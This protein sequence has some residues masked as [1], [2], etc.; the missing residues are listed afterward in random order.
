MAFVALVTLVSALFG[1]QDC[2][3]HAQPL[4]QVDRVDGAAGC[5]W[6]SG[7]LRAALG[8][9]GSGELLLV[10]SGESNA[11]FAVT[12]SL[13]ATRVDR[14]GTLQWPVAMASD[15]EALLIVERGAG[16]VAI[17]HG[18]THFTLGGGVLRT[19]CAVA[20]DGTLVA[21]ADDGLGEVLVFD[22][23]A[24]NNAIIARHQG[25][26]PSGVAFDGFG[27]LWWSDAEKHQLHCVEDHGRGASKAFGERGSFPGQ[28]TEP[29]A[30]AARDGCL[31][32]A[33]HLNHRIAIVHAANGAFMGYW[34]MHAVVPRQG[35]GRIHYPD[36]IALNADGRIAAITEGFEDRVQLF[37]TGGAASVDDGLGSGK[38]A[39]SS[40]FGSE[41]ACAGGL[42]AMHEPETGAV[43]LFDAINVPPYNV[44]TVGASGAS[45]GRYPSISA[46]G[47]FP[48]GKR[49]V[50][51]DASRNVFDVWACEIDRTQ[52]LIWN[53]FGARLVKSLD[54]T[55]LRNADG[56]KPERTPRIVDIEF[57]QETIYAL[58]SA[59]RSIVQL[60]WSFA[61]LPEVKL[62]EEIR[63]PVEFCLIYGLIVVADPASQCLWSREGEKPDEWRE[64][65]T[66]LLPDGPMP[67]IRPM[68]VA[69]TAAH[70]LVVSDAGRDSVYLCTPSSEKTVSA[71]VARALS[72]RGEL[73]EEFWM[74][75]GVA[76]LGD[77]FT[78]VDR[79]NHRFQLFDANGQWTLTTS[80]SR[81]YTRK[82]TPATDSTGNES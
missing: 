63:E 37:A 33:D 57:Q 59:N 2:P 47:V 20:V 30:L 68:G 45:P 31:F 53:A 51:A 34:G 74:P 82:R 64:I 7:D 58:D 48:D 13:T 62:P 4:R 40:H 78:A 5:A 16:R 21:V 80:L 25:T 42:L 73:D 35:D 29:R 50:I 32:V 10:S 6:I 71:Q 41:V 55:K 11:V 18:D 65:R 79:G 75:L 60:S 15:D 22:L 8:I 17:F 69:S 44:A 54:L 14:F 19:P 46:L 26:R 23:A 61:A 9:E 1:A 36:A 77:G 49:F 38:G 3:V 72:T 28:F 12:D 52:P 39:V 27:H 67:F 70:A 81:F 43:I 66:L 24:P 76:P 56:S